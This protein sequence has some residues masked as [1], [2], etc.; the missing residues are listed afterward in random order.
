MGQLR[1]EP[2]ASIA[3]LRAMAPAWDR[4]WQASGVSLPTARA[5]LV[6]QWLEQFARRGEFRLLVVR[7][8]DD[9]VAALPLASRPVKGLVRVGDLT[10]NMWSANGELLL[11][12]AADG[13]A[14]LDLLAAG[15]ERLPWPLMWFDFVP[16]ES[17][18]WTPFLQALRRRRM[19]VDVHPRYR[20]GQV[21]IAG[22]FEQYMAARSKNLRRSME[23]DLRRMERA[24]PLRFRVLREFTPDEVDRC[25]LEAFELERRS[26]R[27]TRGQTVL[28]APGVFEFYRRQA[29]Q[30]AAWG[31]LRLA[32]LDHA[33]RAVAC[34]FGFTAKGVYHSLKVAYDHEYR[35]YGPGHLLRMHLVRAL[36]AGQDASLID[37]QGPLTDALSQWSTRSY[38]I[39]R[40]VIATRQVRSRLWFAAY[41]GLAGAIRG[42]RSCPFRK[43]IEAAAG[44]AGRVLHGVVT[45][46]RTT[47][48]SPSPVKRLR[49]ASPGF[50][51]RLARIW[52]SKQIFAAAS[53]HRRSAIA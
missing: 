38:P 17:A 8:G 12:P 24:G 20:I 41:R 3:Q 51:R 43:N 37:F 39:G 2:I 35:H 6:A 14:A 11:D 13:E 45:A 32:F 10:W 36:G 27:L 26:W 15:I 16:Y 9:F 30:L 29:R 42:L 22:G 44:G 25:V 50:R 4:L 18:W 49:E 31:E 46:R 5:E 52:G 47:T 40:V 7:D 28:D 53:H 1:L 21:E 48:R 33:G 34:E 23:K 19:H